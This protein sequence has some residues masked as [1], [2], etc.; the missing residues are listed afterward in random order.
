[1]QIMFLSGTK[2]LGRAQYQN[3]FGLTQKIWT[4]TKHFGTCRRTRHRF[5]TFHQ[6]FMKLNA[7]IGTIFWWSDY[8]VPLFLLSFKKGH[9]RACFYKYQ[10]VI[11]RLYKV[12]ICKS[13]TIFVYSDK[14]SWGLIF[15]RIFLLKDGVVSCRK[16][17]KLDCLIMVQSQRHND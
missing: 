14:L 7:K 8:V 16:E 3:K 13:K 9:F 11:S 2:C 12:K 6:M 1:M 15:W 10:I 17:T 4:N 5:H